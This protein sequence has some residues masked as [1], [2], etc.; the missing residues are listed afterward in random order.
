MTVELDLPESGWA[1]H[2]MRGA[3]SLGVVGVI[4]VVYLIGPGG[5]WNVRNAIRGRDRVAR[6][7]WLLV[8]VGVANFFVWLWKKVG[9]GVRGSMARV[10]EE[11]IDVGEEG[12]GELGSSASASST[13]NGNDGDGAAVEQRWWETVWHGICTFLGI[14]PI[15]GFGER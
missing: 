5:W 2:F 6:L 3:A 11:V 14:G 13:A 7:G 4:K 9:S 8:A 1:A 12:D 15:Q 10:A